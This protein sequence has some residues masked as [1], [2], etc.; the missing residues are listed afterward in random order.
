MQNLLLAISIIIIVFFLEAKIKSFND[1]FRNNIDSK[2]ESFENVDVTNII[3]F[4]PR[5]G[6]SSTII[7]IKGVGLDYIGNILFNNVECVIL[8]DRKDNEIKILP[9]SLTELGK[10]IQEV[11]TIMNDGKDIG[12]G[13]EQI[14]IK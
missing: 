5:Q 1:L 14:K 4:E 13:T 6:D 11:R 12:L 7:T 10:T 3:S 8:D 2:I 9:P